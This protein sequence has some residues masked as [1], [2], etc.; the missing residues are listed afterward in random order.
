M[1]ERMTNDKRREKD[2]Y[3]KRIVDNIVGNFGN[4]NQ[5]EEQKEERKKNGEEEVKVGERLMI[6]CKL[7]RMKETGG[8]FERGLV[9][10]NQNYSMRLMEEGVKGVK[11]RISTY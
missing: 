2:H 3:L 4:D 7:T 5:M 10:S 9:S 8:R 1:E 11:D 6:G